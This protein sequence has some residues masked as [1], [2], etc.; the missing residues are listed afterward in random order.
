[1]L[2]SIATIKTFA[3]DQVLSFFVK[4]AIEH[5]APENDK[6]HLTG[7]M[8]SMEQNNHTF[9]QHEK[10][11]NQELL[12]AQLALTAKQVD[13]LQRAEQRKELVSQVQLEMQKQGLELKARQ[14][15]ENRQY[16]QM[17]LHTLE[18]QMQQELQL[19]QLELQAQY[20]QKHWAS[21]FSRAELQ[22]IFSKSNSLLM[23]VSKPETEIFPNL[24]TRLGNKLN[25]FMGRQFPEN[26]DM[27]PVQ[28]YTDFF[29]RAVSKA[30]LIKL[31]SEL[32]IPTAGIYVEITEPEVFFNI[33]F[34]G[35]GKYSEEKLIDT[36]EWNWVEYKEQLMTE[37]ACDEKTALSLVEETIIQVHK[38]LAGFLADWYYLSINPYHS[39]RLLSKEVEIEQLPEHWLLPCMRTLMEMKKRLLK[40]LTRGSL[41]T[42]KAV[43]AGVF[44]SCTAY[45]KEFEING[46]S[47]VL[48]Q[49]PAGEFLMGSETGDVD[50]FPVHS[51]KIT[52]PFY[53]SKFPITQQQWQAIM[54]YNPSHFKGNQDLPVEN[55]S[56]QECVAFCGKLSQ[57]TAEDFR[58]PSES[59]W[60]YA[61]KAETSSKYWWGDIMDTH[62]CW[63]GANSGNK[64]HSV[65]EATENHRNPFGL[66]DMTGN[67]WEWCAD[68][69][70]NNYNVPRTQEAFVNNNEAYVLRGG[71]WFCDAMLCRSTSRF[72]SV[73]G[74]HNVGF[75]VAFFPVC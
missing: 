23:I 31:Q 16:G 2:L 19:R 28:F 11:K 56:W 72:K 7:R 53:L 73:T 44:E 40:V 68:S 58:L 1:M 49:I 41:I 26:D 24:A 61:C 9:F 18:T 4:K 14:I 22:K 39:P 6:E 51:V 75:R 3:L 5:F 10:H 8:E 33:R 29:E 30:D 67:V 21:I 66:C 74:F 57:L 38:V 71:S 42:F 20:D 54:G 25:M 12:R 69:W 36:L 59:E 52:K 65:R 62:H 43:K 17:Y 60:E 63:H 34:E 45:E 15:E 27:N 46:I 50:E 55:V 47:L 64:T 32:K 70:E 37:T 48:I 35:M 13:L